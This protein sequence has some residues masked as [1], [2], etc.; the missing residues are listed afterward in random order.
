MYKKVL[1]PVDLGHP[2][3]AEK[4]LGIAKGLVAAGGTL[5]VIHVV[6]EV[7]AYAMTYIPEDLVHGRTDEVRARV[8][9]MLDDAGVSAA[10]I[11]I[12]SGAAH[13]KILDHIEA[14][15][16]DL[17]IVGSHQPGLSDYFLGSTAA[18]IVRHA[19][20]SVLVDR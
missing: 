17:V 6:P 2:E 13:I 1:V 15:E 19:P 7:P 16:P 20:C 18:R 8:Q 3:V 14:A 4:I 9:K 5:S 12:V 10:E 11:L